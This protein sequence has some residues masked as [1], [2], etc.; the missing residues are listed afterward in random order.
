MTKAIVKFVVAGLFCVAGIGGISNGAASD[1]SAGVFSLIM[2]ISFIIWGSRDLEK[3][4]ALKIPRNIVFAACFIAFI[5][6]MVGNWPADDAKQP[7]TAQKTAKPNDQPAAVVQKAT[8]EPQTIG[9]DKL[10]AKFL[11]T[12]NELEISPEVSQKGTNKK[13]LTK[14][15]MI[16]IPNYPSTNSASALI[17]PSSDAPDENLKSVALVGAYV[18]AVVHEDA[19]RSLIKSVTDSIKTNK[20]HSFVSGEYR[21]AVTPPDKKAAMPMIFVEINKI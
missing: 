12:L 2:G 17:L 3:S 18:K 7:I 15:G 13:F 11:S 16:E 9:F 21:I 20:A 10:E 4:W 6:A 5:G 19:A 14:Y 8:P 1:I